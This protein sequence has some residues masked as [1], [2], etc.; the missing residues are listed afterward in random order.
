[1]L[2]NRR[3]Q[4]FNSG[5]RRYSNFYL[6]PF[7]S[8]CISLLILC[9][10]MNNLISFGFFKLNQNRIEL[11][12]CVNKYK[13]SK[14]CHGKCYLKKKLQEQQNQTKNPFHESNQMKLDHFY[15]PVELILKQPAVLYSVQTTYKDD[16]ALSNGFLLALEHPPDGFAFV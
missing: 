5:N 1:M 14:K 2:F 11:E 9:S 7:F 13:P 15:M 10:S 4:K 12:A 8:L 16:E 3:V 6:D